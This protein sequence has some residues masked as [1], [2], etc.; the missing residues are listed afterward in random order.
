MTAGPTGLTVL[1]TGGAGFVGSHLAASLAADNAVVVLDDLSAG[2]KSN[3]PD[4]ATFVR[5]DVR[6]RETIDDLLGGVDVVF[7]Q[8]GL[9][10]VGDSVERPLRSHS[11]NVRGTLAV[12]EAARRNDVRVV[13]AS[14]AAIYGDPETTP[15][16]ESDPLEPRSP[17][18]VDKLAADHY[19]RRYNDLYGLETVALR[20]FNV[21]GP[22]QSATDYSGV[23]STFVSQASDDAPLTVHGDGTQTRDFVHVDDVVRANRLA[24]TTDHLGEAFNVGTGT[25]VTI[26]DLAEAVRE[27]FEADSAVVHTEPRTGDVTHSRADLSRARQRLG[28]EPTVALDDGLETL[29]TTERTH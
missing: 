20:Y 21:Y 13:F 2:S 14:S 17:Y 15:V 23:I 11:M 29:T 8:A 10:S 9:V 26:Y 6:D 25:A 1:V 19:V 3:V 7:H 5:G 28:Y 4:E 12:L 18:G 22:G 16:A 27:C 24:A